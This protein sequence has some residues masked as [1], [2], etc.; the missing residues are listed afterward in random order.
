MTPAQVEG[1]LG[2]PGDYRTG[3]LEDS[4]DQFWYDD[5]K[6]FMSE[7]KGIWLGDAGI[8]CIDYYTDGGSQTVGNASFEPSDRVK[9]YPVQNF[10][11]RVK[12]QWR[13]WFG[14]A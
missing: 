12:R 8:L 5:G 7:S 6:L 1:I 2:P 9:Q 4:W 13:R 14:H 3:P 10:V 11:W